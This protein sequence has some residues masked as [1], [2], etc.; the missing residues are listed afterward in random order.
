LKIANPA[1]EAINA[2]HH[3]HI[4]LAEEVEHCSQLFPP[5]RARAAALTSA[6]D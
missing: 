2:P 4:T 6:L 5:R 1:G 3:Q